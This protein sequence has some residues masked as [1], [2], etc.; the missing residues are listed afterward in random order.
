MKHLLNLDYIDK[1]AGCTA[2]CT[3]EGAEGQLM[4]KDTCKNKHPNLDCR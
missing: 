4:C 3:Y 1:N 2:G